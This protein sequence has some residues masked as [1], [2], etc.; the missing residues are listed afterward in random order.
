MNKLVFR[1]N[2][3]DFDFPEAATGV[4]QEDYFSPDISPEKAKEMNEMFSDPSPQTIPEM[5]ITMDGEGLDITENL[6]TSM[7]VVKLDMFHDPNNAFFKRQE[8]TG[9]NY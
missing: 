4:V 1:R 6:L 7:G 5:G 3:W 8:K 2:V 9:G